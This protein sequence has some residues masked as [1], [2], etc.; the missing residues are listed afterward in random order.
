[1]AGMPLSERA[2]LEAERLARQQRRQAA[3][4]VGEVSQPTA[5]TSKTSRALLLP[6]DW[7]H[8]PL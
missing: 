3:L 5:S 1:M 4:A 7:P 2:T 6:S 8:L